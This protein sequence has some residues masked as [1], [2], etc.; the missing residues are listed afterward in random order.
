MCWRNRD[1]AMT[2]P[3]LVEAGAADRFGFGDE[4]LALASASHGGEPAHVALAG[5]ML[6]RL[7]LDADAL[8]CGAHWPSHQPSSHALARAGATPSALHNNRSEERRV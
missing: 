3:A 7:G 4:E 5:K 8:E 2:N 6:A 1:L